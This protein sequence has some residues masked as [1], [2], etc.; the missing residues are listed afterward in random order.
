[1]L[2]AGA[3]PDLDHLPVRVDW[4]GIGTDDVRR[5]ELQRMDDGHRAERVLVNDGERT[6]HDEY[7]PTSTDLSWRLRVSRR[8]HG[9]SDWATTAARLSHFEDGASGIRYDGPWGRAHSAGYTG[10]G[11]RWSATRGASLTVDFTGSSIAWL[12][13]IGPTRGRA[14]VILD[15]NDLGTVD[16][17]AA[18]FHPRW[19]IFTGDAGGSGAHTLEVRVADGS[20]PVAVDSFVVL[21]P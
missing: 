20:G 19:V 21:R 6:R 1:M 3:Y 10:N 5:Y 9:T 12:G 8:G 18:A 13:P 2:R 15:G 17:R 4:D 7:A 11:V 14:R 16:L